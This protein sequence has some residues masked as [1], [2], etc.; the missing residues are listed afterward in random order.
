MTSP[1]L[2]K[3]QSY[4]FMMVFNRKLICRVNAGGQFILFA[5][6]ASSCSHFSSNSSERGDVCFGRT[7]DLSIAKKAG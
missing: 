3:K 4:T 2:S 5:I 7:A 1:K 6:K